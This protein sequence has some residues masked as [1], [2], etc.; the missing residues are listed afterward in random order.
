M[1]RRKQ[2]RE[3]KEQEHECRYT[4]RLRLAESRLTRG[5]QGG[6]GGREDGMWSEKRMSNK[7]YDLTR[8]D[9]DETASLP[10]FS[11]L[12]IHPTALWQRGK[13]VDLPYQILQTKRIVS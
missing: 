8:D 2:L 6:E 5:G 9:T 10:C 4:G 11:W 1:M 7:L 3:K 12:T 13:I